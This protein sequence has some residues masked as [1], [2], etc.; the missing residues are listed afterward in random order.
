MDQLNGVMHLPRIHKALGSILSGKQTNQKELVRETSIDNS[1]V[2][3]MSSP[4]THISS[5]S[6]EC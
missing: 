3:S 1:S 4:S 6:L 5:S 2:V